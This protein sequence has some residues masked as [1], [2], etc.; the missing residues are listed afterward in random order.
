LNA[1]RMLKL[2]AKLKKTIIK[3]N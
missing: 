1:I 2:G 3:T